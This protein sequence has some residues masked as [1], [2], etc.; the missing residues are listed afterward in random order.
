MIYRA[1]AGTGDAPTGSSET[2]FENLFED[3][4]DIREWMDADLV[5]WVCY[6][7]LDTEPF[8]NDQN[9]DGQFN[10]FAP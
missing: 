1:Q 10:V 2:P 5:D 9:L 3:L 4:T 7:P 6:L 8:A